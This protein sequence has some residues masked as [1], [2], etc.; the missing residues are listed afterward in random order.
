M[1]GYTLRQQ[2]AM[3]PV[4]CAMSLI[5]SIIQCKERKM[6]DARFSARLDY[7]HYHFWISLHSP[8]DDQ[9]VSK[10][11]KEK[12]KYGSVDEMH[13]V[14]ELSSVQCSLDHLF[15]VAGPGER[16]GDGQLVCSKQRHVCDSI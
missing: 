10:G 15:V 1:M 14:C 7:G 2:Y 9:F 8:V 16:S 6:C 3:F 13:S 11:I 5:L 12:L 4:M